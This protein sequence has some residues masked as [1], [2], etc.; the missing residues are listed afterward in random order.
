MGILVG[1]GTLT[2]VNEFSP[3]FRLED[4][5]TYSIGFFFS[6][7]FGAGGTMTP[8]TTF[9]G[10][11][12]PGQRLQIGLISNN[13][14]TRTG[15]AFSEVGLYFW[16]GMLDNLF[17]RMTAGEPGVSNIDYAVYVRARP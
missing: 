6:G 2:I 7:T 4:L 12:N 5:Y 11:S 3:I 10:G 9:S 8:Y 17:F 14:A 13:S 16:S 1:S 15:L